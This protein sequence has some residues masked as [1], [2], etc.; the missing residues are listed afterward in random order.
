MLEH[1]RCPKLNIKTN[2]SDILVKEL[3][4]LVMLIE[5]EKK[6]KIDKKNSI[7]IIKNKLKYNK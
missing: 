1:I 2:C 6:S 7:L 5:E 3:R 4:N